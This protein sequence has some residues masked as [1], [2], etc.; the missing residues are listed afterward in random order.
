MRTITYDEVKAGLL[1]LA[2]RH[3]TATNPL[4]DDGC[5]Y[6]NSRGERCIISALF[7]N[8]YDIE[9]GD[10]GAEG[11][12]ASMLS[13][14]DIQVDEDTEVFLRTVQR[15]ADG[16]PEVDHHPQPWGEAVQRAL[17]VD[18]DAVAF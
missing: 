6:L 2:E 4:T 14:Y 1:T 16:L 11:V 15:I 12:T 3:P 8:S 17:E 18:P 10:E 9:L 5:V 7:K 13:G